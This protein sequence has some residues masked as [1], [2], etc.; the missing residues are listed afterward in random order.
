MKK[1]K[2]K[3]NTQK[4]TD[5]DLRELMGQNMQQLKRAKGG[6]YNRK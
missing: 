1:K 6:A 4:L 5:R 2:P 3:K